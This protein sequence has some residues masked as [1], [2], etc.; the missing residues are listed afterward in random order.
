MAGEAEV[1]PGD[2]G[3]GGA[4]V[5]GAEIGG[6]AAAGAAATVAA[7]RSCAADEEPDSFASVA[8]L[9]FVALPSLVEFAVAVATAGAAGFVA[10]SP[11]CSASLSWLSCRRFRLRSR[12]SW[13]R[14]RSSFA[15][16]RSSFATAR[17]LSRSAPTSV[18]RL[19]SSSF[20]L[21]S[22]TRASSMQVRS[23]SSCGGCAG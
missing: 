18:R 5:A 3:A 19:F 14:V 8:P 17:A 22:P 16:V 13:N 23:V 9:S 4:V 10:A 1:T 12:L 20:S 21:T 7:G 15:S 6:A 11:R 2:A